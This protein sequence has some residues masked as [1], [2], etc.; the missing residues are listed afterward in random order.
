MKT[1]ICKFKSE[2]A[3]IRKVAILNDSLSELSKSKKNEATDICGPECYDIGEWSIYFSVSDK[4]G[5]EVDFKCDPDTGRKTLVP[6]RAIT[7]GGE[8]AGVV[9]DSQLVNITVR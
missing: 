5:Y 4:L 3:D 7:W 2:G 1:I 8:D 6:V 9:I